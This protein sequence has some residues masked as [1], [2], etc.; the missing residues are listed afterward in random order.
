MDF[1]DTPQKWGHPTEMI[2]LTFWPYKKVYKALKCLQI[3][4]RKT[5]ILMHKNLQLS[6]FHVRQ[7][8]MWLFYGKFFFAHRI[9]LQHNFL[10]PFP[11]LFQSS[12]LTVKISC[13]WSFFSF[14]HLFSYV[15]DDRIITESRHYYAL[16]AI[17][18]FYRQRTNFG[19]YFYEMAKEWIGDQ[20]IEVW[21]E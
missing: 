12:E 9:K 15:W 17:W 10:W 7:C 18:I 21:R 2:I 6:V 19:H 5:L 13:L 8:K 3:L 11:N 16:D 4:N 1:A 14:W 20:Q